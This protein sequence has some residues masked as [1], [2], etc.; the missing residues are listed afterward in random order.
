MRKLFL[1]HL[2]LIATL[3]PVTTACNQEP[4]SCPT[5][6]N[7]YMLNYRYLDGDACDVGPYLISVD[8]G[9]SGVKNTTDRRA[10]VTIYTEVQLSGCS[11]RLQVDIIN[12]RSDL[13]E[14]TVQGN[15]TVYNVNR[16]SGV[17]NGIKYDLDGKVQCEGQF[18]LTL[19]P[20]PPD[21]ITNTGTG[22]MA[23]PML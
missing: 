20:P 5:I 19:E 1:L 3:L 8:G 7:S 22:G 6:D 10:D 12:N 15:L 17:A 23:A 4:A 16:I 9:G 18:E 21:P 14:S 11:L 13:Q 2:V